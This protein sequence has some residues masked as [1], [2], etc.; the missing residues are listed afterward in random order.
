[1]IQKKEADAVTHT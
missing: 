1:M